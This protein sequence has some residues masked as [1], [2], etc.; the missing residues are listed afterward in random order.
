VDE[1]GELEEREERAADA[2]ERFMV[3]KV[4]EIQRVEREMGILYRFEGNGE[5]DESRRWTQ[6]TAR[7]SFG[8]RPETSMHPNPFS[9]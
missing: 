5:G 7:K 4:H 9:V 3:A 1:Y 6:A 8:D 2:N